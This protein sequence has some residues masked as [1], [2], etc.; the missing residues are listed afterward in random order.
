MTEE[1]CREGR[2][3]KNYRRERLGGVDMNVKEDDGTEE[4][5]SEPSASG[6]GRRRNIPG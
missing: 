1:D 5:G 3:M 2:C 6:K 4:R